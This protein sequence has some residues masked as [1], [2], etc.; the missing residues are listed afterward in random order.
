[1][2]R[3]IDTWTVLRLAILFWLSMLLV[4][5]VAGVLLWAVAS[6]AGVF[7]NIT[8]FMASLGFEKF[9]FHGGVIF[10]ASAL[11][12][13]VLVLLGTGA[14]V[15]MA[16]LY[17]LISDVVGGVEFVVLEE[18]PAPRPVATRPSPAVPPAKG[19]IAVGGRKA[20]ARSGR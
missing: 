4:L 20:P 5:L 12:G 10:R 17:N 8:K 9:R 19:G 1:V 6:A 15:L 14:T 3:K 7:P 13:V 18:E 2:V 11:A 16:V